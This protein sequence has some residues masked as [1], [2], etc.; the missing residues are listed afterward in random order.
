MKVSQDFFHVPDFL[1]LP[2]GQSLR[3]SVLLLQQADAAV[4]AGAIR[5]RAVLSK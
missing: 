5:G 4:P 1:H 2:L 3:S